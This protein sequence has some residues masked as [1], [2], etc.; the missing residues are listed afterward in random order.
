MTLYQSVT[1]LNSSK[2]EGGVE[3]QA[4]TEKRLYALL[5]LAVISFLVLNSVMVYAILN[6]PIKIVPV[7]T[8]GTQVNTISV[9]GT[10]SITVAP[11][12]AHVS[13]AVWTQAVTATDALSSNADRM[14]K[15]IKALTDAGVAME[16]I[17]TTA[18]S[19]DPI[20]T[21][22]DKA[23]ETPKIVGYMARNQID[24]TLTDVT[25]VGRIID[26]GV[27]G[28]AN[29]V[30]SVYFTISDSK[31]AQVRDQAIQ[32]AVKDA[33]SKAKVLAQ[34]Q[35]LKLTGPTSITLGYEYPG[36]VY[37][38]RIGAAQTTPIIPGPLT[39]TANVQVTYSFE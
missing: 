11:D 18:Y 21:Y 5:I 38:E 2:I 33:D 27:A 29:V 37:A 1:Y 9:S 19:L 4:Q 23:T 15:V 22:P 17:K 26:A 31:S 24:V 8:G 12:E 25:S 7:G 13:F 32:E 28:G 35:N 16:N 20:I 39:V 34:S 6:K 30:Q 14:N 3:M 10:G 36:P